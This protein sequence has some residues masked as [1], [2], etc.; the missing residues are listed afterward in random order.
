MYGEGGASCS[1]QPLLSQTQIPN[2]HPKYVRVA[3]KT[4]IISKGDATLWEVHPHP[5]P[6]QSKITTKHSYNEQY[7]WKIYVFSM[8]VHPLRLDASFTPD[9]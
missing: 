8:V 5:L 6:L 2:P 9:N 4:C 3:V 1:V 7:F